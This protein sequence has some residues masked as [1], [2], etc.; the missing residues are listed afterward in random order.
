[1][2]A[3]TAKVSDSIVS[4]GPL[5]AAIGGKVYQWNAAKKAWRVIR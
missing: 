5:C 4:I 2:K 3:S 1:M